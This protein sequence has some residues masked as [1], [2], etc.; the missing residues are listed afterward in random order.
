MKDTKAVPLAV[1]GV[2]AVFP[3]AK[4]LREY[5]ANVKNKVDAIRDVP[6]SHWS[7]DEYFDK[8]PKKPDHVYA[9]K[10]GFLDHVEFDKDRAQKDHWHK[11]GMVDAT[12]GN[13]CTIHKLQ[14]SGFLNF[15]WFD[16][17]FG[18]GDDRNKHAYTAITRAE[19][20]L[21]ILA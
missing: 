19:E 20:G 16:D 9:Y 10:G 4:T 7:R 21:V 8:D 13:A 15:I 6:E 17:G 11:K 18:R 5:W 14:G 2:A 3:K 12:Y 1:V